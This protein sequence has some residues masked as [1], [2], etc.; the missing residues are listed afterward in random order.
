M[1][2]DLVENSYTKYELCKVREGD[3]EKYGMHLVEAATETGTRTSI[4]RNLFFSTLTPAR[5]F[6]SV[7]Q[8]MEP[9]I[10]V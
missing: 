2:N 3:V 9:I 7:T 6:R 1:V 10:S 5:T 8:K 4:A